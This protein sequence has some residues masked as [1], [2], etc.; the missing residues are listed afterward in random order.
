MIDAGRV[1]VALKVRV[2]HV[3]PALAG[4]LQMLVGSP[5]VLAA[6]ALLR[7][8]RVVPLEILFRVAGDGV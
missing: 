3:R 5:A 6:S 8:L 4:G 1:A 2:L 7:V